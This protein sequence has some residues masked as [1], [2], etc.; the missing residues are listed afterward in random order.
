MQFS[1]WIEYRKEHKKP[2]GILLEDGEKWQKS[3]SAMSRRLL[4]P[5]EISLFLNSMHGVSTDIVKRLKTL[6]QKEGQNKDKVP[7]LEEELFSWAFESACTVFFDKRLG[8]LDKKSHKI[9]E[10][11]DEF[12]YAFKKVLATSAD[13][14]LM[15]YSIQRMLKTKSYTLHKQSWDLLF[16]V[17]RDLIDM[18][19][20]ELADKVDKSD[21]E[22]VDDGS[23]LAYLVAQDKLSD[24]EI[25]GNMTELLAAAVDTTSN[26]TLW[27]LYCLAK[28]PQ[29]QERLY[30]EVKRV[31]P[32]GITPTKDHYNQMSYLKAVM[33]ETQRLF[34]I[35]PGVS[36]II[37]EDKEINGFNIPAGKTVVLDTYSVTRNPEYFEDPL[38]FK[39]ERWLDRVKGER[40]NKFLMLPFGVGIRSCIGRRLAEQE[41]HTLLPM[42][43]KN[44]RLEI[45]KE[46]KS[47]SKIFLV[48]DQPLDLR[49]VDRN[50][51]I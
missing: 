17:S 33:Q 22:K 24:E 5:Q 51:I 2:L 14:M 29:C 42:I 18:K 26:S 40:L 19:L 28:N 37:Q 9:H 36:R 11:I 38:S 3:R 7:Y 21:K 12:L 1:P 23:F 20:N 47:V 48:P 25:Y 46:V 6:R 35:V 27:I 15:P 8:I 30:E 13:L 34:P 39:P 31:F 44:F 41:M 43:I 45:D 49:L 32:E 16:K 50:A 10:E 4:R